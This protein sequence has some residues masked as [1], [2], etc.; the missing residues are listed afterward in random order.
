[1]NYEP[2]Q[3]ESHEE[4]AQKLAKRNPF[5]PEETRSEQDAR[6]GAMIRANVDKRPKD[7]WKAVDS[8]L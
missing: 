3:L 6:V 5:E 8:G 7:L 1:M 2:V 4:F